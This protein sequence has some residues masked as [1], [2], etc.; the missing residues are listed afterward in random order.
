MSKSGN[1]AQDRGPLSPLKAKQAQSSR[2]TKRGTD[3]FILQRSC[4][5]RTWRRSGLS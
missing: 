4:P 2:S 5:T 3:G 1:A